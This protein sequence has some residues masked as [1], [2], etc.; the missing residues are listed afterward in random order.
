MITR[1]QI[2]LLPGKIVENYGKQYLSQRELPSKRPNINWQLASRNEPR[3]DETVPGFKLLALEFSNFTEK[4]RSANMF[5]A[6]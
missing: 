3:G 6:E 4:T 2:Q 1:Y 5:P